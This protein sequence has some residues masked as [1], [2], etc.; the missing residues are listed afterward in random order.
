MRNSLS[1]AHCSTF[2]TH[3]I[4]GSRALILV[5]L[6]EIGLLRFVAMLRGIVPNCLLYNS[7]P[8]FLLSNLW[9]IETY[10]PQTDLAFLLWPTN[11]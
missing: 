3:T 6:F 9:R 5:L 4:K 1:T 11:V 7:L 2:G 8:G 10:H